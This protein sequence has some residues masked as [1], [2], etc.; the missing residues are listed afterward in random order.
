MDKLPDYTI[1]EPMKLPKSTRWRVCDAATGVEIGFVR[2]PDNMGI[3]GNYITA[4]DPQGKLVWSRNSAAGDFLDL[5]ARALAGE[6]WRRQPAQVAAQQAVNDAADAERKQRAA[7][8]AKAKRLADAAPALLDA[9]RA[10]VDWG[11]DHTSPLDADSPHA[12]LIVGAAAIAQAE[13]KA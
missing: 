7:A 10:L 5:G 12:L 3:A 9:L 2:R 8:A 6:H 1:G 13:E 4:K 11:R